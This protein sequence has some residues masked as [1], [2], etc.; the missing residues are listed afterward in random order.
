MHI[1]SKGKQKKCSVFF[2]E[3]ECSA[4]GKYLVNEGKGCVSISI[5]YLSAAVI[6][7]KKFLKSSRIILI[8]RYRG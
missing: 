7:L 4:D 6:Y 5:Y 1:K 3:K 2:V 8:L